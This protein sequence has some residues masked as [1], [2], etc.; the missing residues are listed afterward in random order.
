MPRLFCTLGKTNKQNKTSHH[1]KSSFFTWLLNEKWSMRT[2]DKAEAPEVMGCK[3]SVYLKARS[4]L[5]ERA[6]SCMYSIHLFQFMHR[7]S[8][9]S[10]N[11]LRMC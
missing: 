6:S 11:V 3:S 10:H 4:C 5:A 9:G 8:W 2:L 7:S 1:S